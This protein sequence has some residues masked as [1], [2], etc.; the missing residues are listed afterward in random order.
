[1]ISPLIFSVA[2]HGCCES[3]SPN[4]HGGCPYGNEHFLGFQRLYPIP[5]SLDENTKIKQG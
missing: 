1:M 2:V 4:P 3:E 5:I